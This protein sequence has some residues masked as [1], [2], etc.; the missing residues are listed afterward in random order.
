MKFKHLTI[1]LLAALLLIAFT[2]C[3]AESSETFY[4]KGEAES[5]YEV[6]NGLVLGDAMEAPSQSAGGTTPTVQNQ[7]LVRT[8]RI[9]AQT[10]D[11]DPL[12]AQLESKIQQLGGY[13]ESKNVYN[14]VSTA[15]RTTRNAELVI[16]VP[17]DSLDEF[18]EHIRGQSNV[19]SL[20][21]TVDD[22]TLRYVAVESRITALETEQQRLL[23]LLEKAENMSDLLQI[24]A[25]LTEVRTELEQMV[26]QMRI[27]DN[28]VD[29]GTLNLSI[30]EVREYTEPEVEKTVWQRIGIG[31][32]DSWSGLVTVATDLFVFLVSSLPVLIPLGAIAFG[33]IWVIRK[34]TKKGKA[35]PQEM[36][37]YP[38]VTQNPEE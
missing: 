28:L 11:M 19:V 9:Q 17:A 1:W 12:L 15:S 34:K 18:A 24:E 37:P 4:S 38:E 7:K 10:Q 35:Q 8:M 21:E 20:N 32:S 33:V 25:R 30:T 6:S 36:P 16:R 26:S 27:Y 14:G 2:G 23:E 3:S 22:I 29:Y 5:R 31:L 13:V